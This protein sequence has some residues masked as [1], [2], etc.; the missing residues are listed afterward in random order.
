[1]CNFLKENTVLKETFTSW[2]RR[3]D[4]IRFSQNWEGGSLIKMIRFENILVGLIKVSSIECTKS[5][6]S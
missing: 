5:F 2:V 6:N 4:A 1:M 3:L